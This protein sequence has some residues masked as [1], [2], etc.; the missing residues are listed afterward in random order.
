MSHKRLGYIAM[1]ESNPGTQELI[2][3]C[4]IHCAMCSRYL[5]YINNLKRSHC[6]GCR[7]ANREC[8]ILKKNC[9]GNKNILKGNISFCF[10]CGF[11]PCKKLDHLDERYR[12][13]YRT[14]MIDNL[15]FIKNNGIPEFIKNQY[16]K[17]R[18]RKC[19]SLISMHN[20]KCF[21]CDTITKLVDKTARKRL[22]S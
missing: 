19:G 8:A 10:E 2:A 14:S 3:P 6:I 1:K 4:G 15:E 11:Y 17:H 12:N 5:S 16:K 7:P 13:N 21:T 20:N 9:S 18:C 22:K